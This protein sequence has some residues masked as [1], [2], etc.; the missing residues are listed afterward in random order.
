MASIFKRGRDKGKRR[1]HWYVAYNDHKGLRRVKKAFTDRAL[2]EQLAAK[3]ENEA[4][5]RERGL[6][7]PEDERIA[8]QKATL[9]TTH[10]EAFERSLA[11][12]SEKYTKLVMSRVRSLIKECGFEVAG[13]LDPD[14]VSETLAEMKDEQGFGHRTYNHY[15][16]GLTTFC[17]WMVKARRLPSNPIVGLERLNVDVDIRHPR[18]ALTPVEVSKLVASARASEEL[19]QCYTGEARARIYLTSYMTGLRRKE[20][21]SLTPRSFDL[22]ATLPTLT[23]QATVSKHRKKDVLPLH[24]ELVAMI[25]EWA[26][27]LAPHELLFPGLDFRRTWL[28]VKKDLARAGIEYETAEG[29]ADFHAAGRH[30]HVTEL[31]RSGASLPEARELARHADIRTTMKYTHIGMDDRARALSNLRWQRIGSAAHDVGSPSVASND[32][33]SAS[34]E[35]DDRCEILDDSSDFDADCHELALIGAD[36]S[37]DADRVRF[38]PPPLNLLHVSDLRHSKR[39]GRIERMARCA[40]P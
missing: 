20:L 31:L 5:L 35:D 11:P 22:N 30:S 18:R 8:A 17:N 39:R 6:I 2:S 10:L 36:A 19:I 28:M 24:P 23:V 37:E 27:P 32:N 3:L 40:V 21:A 14:V 9:L 26:A 33:E 4:M 7:D 15:L 25:R 1:S 29:I 38:P 16:Q 13:D 34:D 12:N